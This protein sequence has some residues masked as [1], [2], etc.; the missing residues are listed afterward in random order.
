MFSDRRELVRCRSAQWPM[1]ARATFTV[2]AGISSIFPVRKAPAWWL[3][4]VTAK[5]LYTRR[6]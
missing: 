2:F 1:V 6:D 4:K 5:Q 3:S